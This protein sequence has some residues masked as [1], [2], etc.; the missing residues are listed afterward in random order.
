MT[1]KPKTRKAPAAKAVEPTAV[2]NEAHKLTD[3][4]DILNFAYIGC[5]YMAA[6]SLSPHQSEPISAVA[7]MASDK[8]QE[9]ISLLEECNHD[10]WGSTP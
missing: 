1:T 7:D 6:A 5:I 10:D 8:I 2:H 3:A 4:M 9:A